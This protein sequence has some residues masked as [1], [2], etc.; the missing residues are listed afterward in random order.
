MWAFGPANRIVEAHLAT[1]ADFSPRNA[2]ARS[3]AKEMQER[4]RED[5]SGQ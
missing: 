4:V 3:N 1:F 2:S 5:S